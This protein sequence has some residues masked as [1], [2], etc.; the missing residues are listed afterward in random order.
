MKRALDVVLAG[1]LLVLLAPLIIAIA[2]AV[3]FDLGWPILFRQRRP[4]LHERPFLICKFRTMTHKCGVSG[5]LLPDED[6]MT[7]FGRF[8][9][10][11]SLDEL[12]ELL[13]VLAGHMSLVG[14]RPLL[15]EY[16]GRYSTEQRRRHE[17]LPGMTGWAQVNGR[18]SLSW[19]DRFRLDVWYVDHESIWLDLKI[20]LRTP[21][22]IL[23]RSGISHQGHATMPRFEGTRD[24][25]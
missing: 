25:T 20:L 9:R 24:D 17:V 19:E 13:N 11:T 5:Q 12:P 16:L 6:R 18:N 3:S 2:I 15:P 4:G 23:H 8:L 21:A 10:S 14:P 1:S 22:S 7:D